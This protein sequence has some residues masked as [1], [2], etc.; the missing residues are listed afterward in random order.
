MV[1]SQE[2]FNKTLSEPLVQLVKT[3]GIASF[4]HI[5]KAGE[6]SLDSEEAVQLMGALLYA[7]ER[8]LLHLMRVYD[9]F[10]IMAVE[11]DDQ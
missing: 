3:I 9:D 8:G 2:E 11:D 1:N 5:L 6:Y 10:L 4:T 7:E